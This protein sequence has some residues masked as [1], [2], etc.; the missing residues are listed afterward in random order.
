[1]GLSV[2]PAATVAAP[3]ETVWELLAYPERY[4][5]WADARVVR[6]EPEGP[7]TVGQTIYLSSKKAGH[8]WPITFT[9]EE[10]NSEK[11]QLGIYARFPLGVQMRPH[12]SCAPIDAGACRVQYG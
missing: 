1:M 5:E 3:V 12:I 7:A 2:C 10:V 9:I 4:G 8:S 6:M 11:H